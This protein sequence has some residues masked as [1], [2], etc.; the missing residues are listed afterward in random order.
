MCIKLHANLQVEEDNRCW[1]KS[2]WILSLS[3][4]RKV[5]Y[6]YITSTYSFSKGFGMEDKR[7]WRSSY[8]HA[9]VMGRSMN[10]T[11]V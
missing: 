1:S 8:S 10:M 11:L 5:I 7:A 3:P 9:S 6:V 4:A 2:E